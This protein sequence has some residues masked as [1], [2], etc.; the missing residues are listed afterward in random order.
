MMMPRP[1]SA[2]NPRMLSYQS[3]LTDS[4]GNPKPDGKL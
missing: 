1:A 2:Q 3:V 4:L